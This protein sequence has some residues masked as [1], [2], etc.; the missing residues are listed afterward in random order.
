MYESIPEELKRQNK[1]VCARSNRKMPLRADMLLAA[2]SAPY[3][4][5][6]YEDICASVSDRNTWC[7]FEQ[8]VQNVGYRICS[9]VGYVF[10]G[11]GVIG[12]DLDHCFEHGVLREEAMKIIKK[13]GSYTEISKSG[14]GIHI[15]VKGRLPFRGSNNRHG[16]EVYGTNR[17]F[18][19]TGNTVGYSELVENQDGIDW[20]I[21]EYFQTE[22]V[23]QEGTRVIRPSMYQRQIR[24]V[25]SKLS[26]HHPKIEQGARNCT[27]LSYGGVLLSKGMDKYDIGEKIRGL[28]AKCCKPPLSEEEVDNIIRSVMKYNRNDEV[29]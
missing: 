11:N 14:E 3:G 10:D 13:I 12:I 23:S 29:L 2:S 19:L 7:S 22:R 8:A 1:W 18:I 21:S 26:I 27:L 20:L 5:F 24:L 16:V 25:D 28:N 4:Y 6:N 9:H 17:F 15:L